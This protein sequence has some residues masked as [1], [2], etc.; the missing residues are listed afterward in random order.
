MKIAYITQYY[1]PHTGGLELVAQKQAE[2]AVENG[3]EVSLVTY[4]VDG[5][6]LGT[7]SEKGVEVHRV[8]GCHFFDTYFGI[9]FVFPG[10]G[11]M[12]RM[13]AEVRKVDVVHVHDVFYISSWVA[14]FFAK[15]L[16]KPLV[17]TQ[18]VA[19]VKHSNSFVMFVQRLVYSSIGKKLFAQSEKVIVY[20]KIVEQFLAEKMSVSN[21]KMLKVRNGVELARYSKATEEEKSAARTKLN[22]PQDRKLALFVG[23]FVP[24]KGYREFYEARGDEYDLVFVGSGTL[25]QEW[26]DADGV[27]VL[28]EMPHKDMVNVYQAV[29]M[30]VAPSKG[31]LFTLVMQEAFACGLPVIATNEDEYHEFD[32]DKNKIVLCEPVSNILKSEMTKLAHDEQKLEDMS[33]YSQELSREL[34]DWSKNIESVF[35]MYEELFNKKKEVL[36]TLSW[37][38]GHVLDARVAELMEKYDIK[39]TF[40]IAPE[41]EELEE[42]ERLDEDA[43]RDLAKNFEIGAHTMT[44]RSLTKLTHVEVQNE[45]VL[46]KEYLERVIGKSVTSFCYPRGKYTREIVAIIRHVGFTV[47]RTVKRYSF[48]KSE[49]SLE[50][51]TSVHTYDHWSD[52]VTMLRFVNYNPITFFKVWR[53]WDRLA[54]YMFDRVKEKGGVFHLWGHSWELEKKDGWKRL[55]RVLQHIGNRDDVAYVTNSEIYT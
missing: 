33:R 16:H 37:D 36:V 11:L 34:F 54:I 3:H 13:Y 23:R 29:D 35:M 43:L 31:E 22:L 32:L 50:M 47:A 20:N 44:H 1:P 46:S 2:S 28:G 38:D 15:L 53:R 27:H 40:Y 21:E 5:T 42:S 30:L 19:T 39:G 25:P 18:H 45:V 10:L 55:E 12:R 52:M 51:Q 9:P 48:A 7:T 17:I 24:K 8:R 14:G 41:N 26:K 4:R 6:A 49:D